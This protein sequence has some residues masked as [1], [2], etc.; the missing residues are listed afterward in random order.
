MEKELEADK[1]QAALDT[2]KDVS[3]LLMGNT[4]IN[5]PLSIALAQQFLDPFDRIMEGL[6][7]FS[8]MEDAVTTEFNKIVDSNTGK[9][10]A[11]LVRNPEPFNHPKIPLKDVLRSSTEPGTVEVLLSDLVTTDTSYHV[12][13]S[14]DYSQALIMNDPKWIQ[15]TELHFQ[16]LYKT[17]NGSE[18]M[19]SNTQ[20]ATNI[21]IN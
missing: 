18:Y 6:F 14:K 9:V 4:L 15:A 8:P 7:G 1:I 13:Y 11:I 21:L 19:V 10:I 20:T 12:L 2:I 5:N 3:N 16:F 17:W